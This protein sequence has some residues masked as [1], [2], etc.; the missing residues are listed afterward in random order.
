MG[1][2]IAAVL[3]HLVKGCPLCPS[4]PGADVPHQPADHR[5]GRGEPKCIGG[6]DRHDHQHLQPAPGVGAGG[7]L[8]HHSGEHGA[9]H[10][11][12]GE[13]SPMWPLMTPS[14]LNPPPRSQQL[15]THTYFDIYFISYKKRLL[16][17]VSLN[18]AETGP[19]AAFPAEGFHRTTA[20]GPLRSR[21]PQMTCHSRCSQSSQLLV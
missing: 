5:H 4:S 12:R 14:F 1:L 2:P 10:Y 15:S 7:V 8:G 20:H 16:A 9:G 18:H 11:D 6:A 17:L 13:S 3:R 21:T 19:G